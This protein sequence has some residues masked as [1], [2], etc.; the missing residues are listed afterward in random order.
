MLEALVGFDVDFHHHPL[1]LVKQGGFL[2][3][4]VRLEIPL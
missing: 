4:V 1:E 2:G 3:V